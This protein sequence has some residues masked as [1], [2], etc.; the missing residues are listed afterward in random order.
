M[1]RVF[2]LAPTFEATDAALADGLHSAQMIYRLGESGSCGVTAIARV[3]G[4]ERP[5]L[6]GIAPPTRMPR[7]SR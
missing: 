2:K 7:C 1:Q 6:P 4:R 3:H 5:V